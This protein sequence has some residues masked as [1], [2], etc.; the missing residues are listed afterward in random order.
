MEANTAY[1]KVFKATSL[2]GGVQII[3][4][5]LN[6]LRGK[7]IALLL[8]ASGMGINSLFVSSVTIISNVTGLGLNFSSVRDISQAVES[9][10]KEKISRIIHVFS[11]WLNVTALLGMIAVLVFSP[12]LSSTTFGS[13]KYT[14]AFLFLSLMVLFNTLSTGNGSMLRGA[15]DNKGYAKLTLTGSAVSLIVSVPLY[16]FF[17]IEAIVPALILSA[18][19]TYLFSL[20]YT[21]KIRK[22]DVKMTL[23]QSLFEGG[24]M[25]KLG[26]AMMATTAITSLVHYL[27]NIFISSKGSVAD[28]GF[29]QAAMNIT[30]QS[31]GLIFTA[32][33]I[34]YQPRLAAVSNDNS[35]VREMVNHQ[36]EI[37]LLIAAPILILLIIAS[38]LMIR[39]LLSEE[40][41]H[42]SG[43]IR[44]LAFGMIFKAA[45]YSIGA[46]SYAKGDKKV[47]FLM[48]GGYTN[49]SFLIFCAVGYYLGGLTGLGYGF[50]IMHI[51]YFI[52][53][54]LLNKRLYNYYMSK[55][56]VGMFAVL[57]VCT[58]IAYLS[59][60]FAQGITAYAISIS[61]S[62]LSLVY[63]YIQMDKRIGIKAFIQEKFL[64]RGL[65]K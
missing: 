38:P 54:N 34:D 40:F 9:G 63:S 58:T 22:S 7:V 11:R 4:V 62:L 48:E 36:A 47:F 25:V 35:K 23:R 1:K 29:Y 2:F 37:T 8:G 56:L 15:R 26:V 28:L 55:E 57:L 19:V 5:I 10:N 20:Y 32:I 53:I 12:I 16:Y 46:I 3:Q 24:D 14:V 33:I 50:V 18:F 52:L 42:I 45:S 21:S 30:N 27:L 49:L 51:L 44:V 39:V 59:F 31:I 60:V 61:A 13:N 65:K 17:G 41:L 6:L 64:N 43:L